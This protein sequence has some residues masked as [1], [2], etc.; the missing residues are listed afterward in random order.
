MRLHAH[1]LPC[2]AQYMKVMCLLLSRAQKQ[3]PNIIFYKL[4][5]LLIQPKLK[6]NLYKVTENQIVYNVTNSHY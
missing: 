5:W 1:V 4:L 3:S 2:I 6:Y